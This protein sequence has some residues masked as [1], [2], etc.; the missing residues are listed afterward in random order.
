M[1]YLL[2]FKSRNFGSVKK[3]YY[4]RARVIIACMPE[5]NLLKKRLMGLMVDHDPPRGRDLRD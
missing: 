3:K 4:M 1:S 2:V 5:N